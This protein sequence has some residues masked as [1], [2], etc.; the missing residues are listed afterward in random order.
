[1][2]IIILMS[3]QEAKKL[4]CNCRREGYAGHFVAG[5]APPL[6]EKPDAGDLEPDYGHFE[7]FVWPTIATRV[8]GFRNVKVSHLAK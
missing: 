7:D 6:G 3:E 1:M 4:F 8:P 5:H 2:Q